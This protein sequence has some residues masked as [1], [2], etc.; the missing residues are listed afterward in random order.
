M[1]VAAQK[2]A[3]DVPIG[4]AAQRRS[5]FEDG[6]LFNTLAKLKGRKTLRPLLR[7]ETGLRLSGEI[8][9]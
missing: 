7:A 5:D 9:S 3:A 1:S 4:G 8:T 6:V 2:V